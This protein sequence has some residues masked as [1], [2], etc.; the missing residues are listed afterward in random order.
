MSAPLVEAT[1]VDLRITLRTGSTPDSFHATATMG[2]EGVDGT[3][4]VSMTADHVRQAIDQAR[5]STNPT[6]SRQ[7]AP[8][9]TD[10]LRALGTQL[11]ERLFEGPLGRVYLSALKQA[12][13][14]DSLGLRL[15][16]VVDDP[17]AAAL[18]WEFLYDP[19]GDAYLALSLRTTVVR[20]RS[21]P[22]VNG[23]AQPSR[24]PGPVFRVLYVM[25]DA[26]GLI[27]GPQGRELLDRIAESHASMRLTVL[28]HPTVPQLAE[29]LAGGC[30]M[31]HYVGLVEDLTIR[32][33]GRERVPAEAF[34]SLLPPSVRLVFL[35][36]DGADRFASALAPHVESV[37]G[38]RGLISFEA[39]LVFAE[40]LHTC[41][42]A[43]GTMEAAVASARRK[44]GAAQPSGREWGLPVLY[45]QDPGARLALAPVRFETS[46]FESL[47]SPSDAGPMSPVGYLLALYTTN[48]RAL[49]AQLAELGD[50]PP[51]FLVEQL[52][53]ERNAAAGL[54][55]HMSA[56][57]V[58]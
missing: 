24:V 6:L 12:E 49:E 5:A 55:P 17:N 32:L 1:Y 8:G 45:T 7:R 36:T 15:R 14:P 26:G 53:D 47:W 25:V 35:D 9:S 23:G 4:T 57:E 10:P 34:L 56:P 28:S 21:G 27:G 42:L 33:G 51:D 54:G 19:R 31:L 30:D 20:Q 58:S 18:P 44:L 11:F 41:L 52:Q 37:V 3:L 22:A 46:P 38:I 13:A 50:A 2:D 39:S 40:G 16:L 43:G 48:I 29:A